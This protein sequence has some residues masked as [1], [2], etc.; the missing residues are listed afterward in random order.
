MKRFGNLWQQVISFAARLRAAEQ[1]CKGKRFW[2]SVAAFYFNLEPELWTLH[3]NCPQRLTG[4]EPSAVRRGRRTHGSEVA[5]GEVVVCIGS[6]GTP[7][8]DLS[9]CYPDAATKNEV[10]HAL[11]PFRRGARL[12]VPNPWT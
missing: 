3:E 1:A 6:G 12:N 8:P 5:A 7:T 10:G 2:P 9:F 11:V 4:L